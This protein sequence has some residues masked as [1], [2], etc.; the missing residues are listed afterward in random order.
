MQRSKGFTLIELLVV[1]AILAIL[2]AIVAPM[3]LER[4]DEA[5]EVVLRDNLF[6]TRQVIDQFYRDQGRYPAQLSELVTKGY[7]RQLPMDPI[8]KR[9]DAW[10][11][12]L[13]EGQTGVVDIRS[14]APGLGKDGTAYTQW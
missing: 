3:Y 13:Q 4:A 12:R 7:I 1:L 6:K 11:L 10:T 2:G 8:L 9:S 5:R 14:S